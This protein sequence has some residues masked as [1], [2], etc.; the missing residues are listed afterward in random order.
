MEHA[1]CPL[2]RQQSGPRAIRPAE[3]REDSTWTRHLLIERSNTVQARVPRNLGQP[4]AEKRVAKIDPPVR[5]R[6]AGPAFKTGATGNLRERTRDRLDLA[7]LLFAAKKRVQTRFTTIGRVAVN[8][9]ALGRFIERRNQ[10]AD[11]FDIRFSRAAGTFLERTQACPR[12]AI[13]AGAVERLSG[14]F[15]SGFSVSHFV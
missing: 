15:G 10:T 9:A 1:N 13:L 4:C 2:L 12:A 5:V 11:L 3:R 8:D 6:V 7:E 14:T